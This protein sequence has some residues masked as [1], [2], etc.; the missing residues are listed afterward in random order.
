MA[1]YGPSIVF[2]H[3]VFGET[4]ASWKEEIHCYHQRGQLLQILTCSLFERRLIAL[5]FVLKFNV[6][7]CSHNK[8]HTLPV[9]KQNQLTLLN[10]NILRIQIHL[11]SF[12]CIHVSLKNA[13]TNSSSCH[14]KFDCLTITDKLTCIDYIVLRRDNDNENNSAYMS[15]PKNLL[16]SHKYSISPLSNF[17]RQLSDFKTSPVLQIHYFH[18]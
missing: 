11:V 2:K 5:Q 6:K 14:H 13:A 3:R 17:E 16:C 15:F 1:C 8:R 12:P 9:I 10:A 4:I 18:A 7:K